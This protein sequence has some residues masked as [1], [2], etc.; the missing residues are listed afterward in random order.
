MFDKYQD[1][2]GAGFSTL[3]KYQVVQVEDLVPGS[4]WGR[5]FDV[6]HVPG[7]SS[8]GF[9]TLNKYPGRSREGFVTFDRIQVPGSFWGRMCDVEQAQ[10]RSRAGFAMWNTG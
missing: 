4:L 3:N 5:I 8:R 1:R 9:A 10:D 2:F 6:K 7:R